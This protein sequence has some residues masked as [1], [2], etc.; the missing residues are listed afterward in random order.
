VTYSPRVSKVDL[1]DPDEHDGNPTSNFTRVTTPLRRSIVTIQTSD[2]QMGDTHTD[3]TSDENGLA[4]KLIDVKDGRDSGEHEQDTTNATGQE[5]A[6]V[7]SQTQ[8][9][10]NE[11]GVV[12]DGVNT[13][14]C[15]LKSV[16]EQRGSDE[17]IPTLLEDHGEN[18]DKNSL[19]KG[20]VGKQGG[21]VVES[22]LEVVTEASRLELGEF[23]SRSV[24]FEHVLGLDFEELEL[25][26]LAIFGCSS[27][28][29]KDIQCLVITVV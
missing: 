20:L 3:G 22:K 27:E 26:N 18:G 9:L 28:A 4:T 2:D 11:S 15:V 10:E 14:P 19:A 6:C 13:R 1:V 5:R 25:Y 29:G 16:G 12:Q 17:R 8:V 23:R 21:V 7:A 24:D